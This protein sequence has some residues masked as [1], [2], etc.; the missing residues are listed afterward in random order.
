MK[1][2]IERHLGIEKMG[3]L[4]YQFFGRLLQDRDF[5]KSICT[6]HLKFITPKHFCMRI[7]LKAPLGSNPAYE[8]SCFDVNIRNSYEKIFRH[9]VYVPNIWTY[10]FF[11]FVEEINIY[12]YNQVI[13][14]VDLR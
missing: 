8:S 4:R 12:G 6:R 5:C 7:C 11:F 1:S 13:K 10:V 3:K 14:G 9:V 2:D